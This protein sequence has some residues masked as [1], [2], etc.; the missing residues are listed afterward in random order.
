MRRET[1]VPLSTEGE[2]GWREKLEREIKEGSEFI[3][4]LSAFAWIPS[5]PVIVELKVWIPETPWYA[6]GV[7]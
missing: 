7:V 6:D 4:W 5:N 1:F 3:L 2:F